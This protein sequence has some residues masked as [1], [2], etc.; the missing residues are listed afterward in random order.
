MMYL[1]S[2]PIG[3]AEYTRNYLKGIKQEQI[4]TIPDGPLIMSPDRLMT[5]FKREV[6]YKKP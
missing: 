6:I 3:Y 2:R 5:S 4:Y 1:T